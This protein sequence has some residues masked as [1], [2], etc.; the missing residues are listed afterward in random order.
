MQRDVVVI[1]AGISGLAAAFYLK[2]KGLDVSLFEKSEHVGGVIRSLH[3]EGY[4][5]EEGPNTYMGLTDPVQEMVE[6]LGLTESMVFPQK[7]ASK[8]FI[9]R[10]G[11]LYRL[12]TNP[13]HYFTSGLLSFSSKLRILCEPLVSKG[14]GDETVGQFFQKRIGPEGTR[15][16][17]DS[18]VC[19]IYAG[20]IDKLSAN[21]CF[22]N[23][24]ELERRHRSIF[25]GMLKSKQ[26][27]DRR[28]F[29]FPQG[30][31]QLPLEISKMLSSNLYLNHHVLSIEKTNKNFY[32]LTFEGPQGEKQL[33]TRSV[34]FA[35][36]AYVSAEVLQRLDSHLATALL[37]VPYTS[38]CVFHFG[39]EKTQIKHPLKGFGFLIPRSQKK[40]TLGVLW[41]S[42]LFSN[43]APEDHK[44]LTVMVGGATDP[45]AYGD[46]LLLNQIK[47][48]LSYMLKIQGKP[49]M[50]HEKKWMK[51]IPQYNIGHVERRKNIFNHLKQYPGLYV[52]GNYLNGVS[53]TQ[54]IEQAKFLS[55]RV[56]SY[57]GS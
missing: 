35:T 36:P 57:L 31:Q 23:L 37:G 27:K 15:I 20:D 16:L 46:P 38:L 21:A 5:L 40:R 6:S 14:R 25:V 2:K 42:S 54:C 44:L 32:T 53:T 18:F 50:V 17:V 4:L 47:S 8:R 28:L 56:S 9:F 19:G 48:E 24:V 52:C 29:S 22:P 1:G 51:A 55:D 12:P 49:K 39:Y 3:K 30:M 41:S 26:K 34:I 11:K 45:T 13:F 43:R 33:E 10:K 7:H